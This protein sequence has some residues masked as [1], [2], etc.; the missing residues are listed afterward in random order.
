MAA[1]N[2]VYRDEGERMMNNEQALTLKEGDIV[3]TRVWGD[4]VRVSRVALFRY[5]KG[6]AT[7]IVVYGTLL[8]GE[9]KGSPVSLT[10]HNISGARRLIDVDE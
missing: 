10:P 1:P 7:S 6:T 4:R 9:A 2:A 3:I 5:P 8:S